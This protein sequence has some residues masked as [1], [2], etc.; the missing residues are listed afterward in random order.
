MN[1]FYCLMLMTGFLLVQPLQLLKHQRRADLELSTTRAV[2][3]VHSAAVATAVGSQSS[4]ARVA[5]SSVSEQLYTSATSTRR[6]D[7]DGRCG[8]GCTATSMT[9]G[10]T[11]TTY[12]A[13]LP[14]NLSTPRIFASL[15]RTGQKDTA[16]LSGI[17]DGQGRAVN[18]KTGASFAVPNGIPAGTIAFQSTITAG[19]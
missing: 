11:M 14:N 17:T 15:G 8:G 13:Q 7:N 10:N 3:G 2:Y 9:V 1:A 4:A 16:T 5:T 18:P 19:Q 12:L 6:D